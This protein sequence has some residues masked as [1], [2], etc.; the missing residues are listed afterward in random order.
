[1]T[2]GAAPR[3]GWRARTRE[4]YIGDND[5]GRSRAPDGAAARSRRHGTRGRDHR[6]RARSS[7]RTPS[8][9]PA[10]SSGRT[11]SS[12]STSGSAATAG[13][14]PRRSSK[15]PTEIGDGNEIFPFASIGLIPQDLKFTASRRELVVGDRNVFREFV[16]IHRGTAG[17]GGV[18]EIGDHNV[19][20][21]YAHIAH[22]CHVGNHTIFGN[23]ATLG[24]HVDGRGLRDDQRVLGR[25][26]VLPRREVRLH[27]RILGHHQGRAAV[28]E[29]RRQPG[30]DLRPEHDRARAPEVL[31]GLDRQAAPR[32]PAPAALEHQPRARPDRARPVA[33]SATRCSTSWTS[34]GRRAAASDCAAQ[35]GA[36]R[37]WSQRSREL[38]ADSYRSYAVVQSTVSQQN[39]RSRAWQLASRRLGELTAE[40][41]C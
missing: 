1:M 14:A 32:L 11:P 16:T 28:C 27:R 30:A 5:R 6:I 10:R 35:A 19:F 2:L 17:G 21:A 4:A 12:A 8:S 33:R 18:T 15:A 24:G 26:P 29:D 25:A 37:K 40:S 22:D 9:A 31:V 20:M 13:S 23:A 39:R 41:D 38:A 36:S 34:S 3:R 7:T